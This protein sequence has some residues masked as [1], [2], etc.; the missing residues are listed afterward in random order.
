MQRLG[1]RTEASE[2]LLRVATRRFRCCGLLVGGASSSSIVPKC[3]R[4]LGTSSI[5]GKTVDGG[6][7][8]SRKGNSSSSE[9]VGGGRAGARGTIRDGRRPFRRGSCAGF[10]TGVVVFDCTAATERGGSFAVVFGCGGCVALPTTYSSSVFSGKSPSRFAS[11]SISL[12]FEDFVRGVVVE[13][14]FRCCCLP[15]LFRPE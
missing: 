13:R 5:E 15:A 11:S 10:W 12:A 14:S 1:D 7:E 4:D 6:F 9:K 3:E 2:K 8:L